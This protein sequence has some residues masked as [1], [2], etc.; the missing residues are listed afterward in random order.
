MQHSALKSELGDGVV[1]GASSVK[2]LQTT[3]RWLS[4]G[5]LG[6]KEVK[7]F[8]EMWAIAGSKKRA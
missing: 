6:E 4:G 7:V 1:F 3:V 5:P 2:Q 8:D